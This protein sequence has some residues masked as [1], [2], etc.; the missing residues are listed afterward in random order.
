[1]GDIAQAIQEGEV[2]RFLRKPQDLTELRQIVSRVMEQSRLMRRVQG[3]GLALKERGE[4]GTYQFKTAYE[5]GMLKV[6]LN[7]KEH[8]ISEDQVIGILNSL[9]NQSLNDLD[10]DIIGGTLVRQQGCM[11]LYAD[12]GFGFQVVFELPIENG[13]G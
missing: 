13:N 3:L 8:K 4:K 10:L 2:Y 6:E 1:V 5:Q 11:M 12:T 7:G 9:F